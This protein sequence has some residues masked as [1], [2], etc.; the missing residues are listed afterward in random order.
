MASDYPRLPFPLPPPVSCSSCLGPS[1]TSYSCLFYDK[2]SYIW[3][4]WWLLFAGWCLLSEVWKSAYWTRQSQETHVLSSRALPASEFNHLVG[5]GWKHHPLQSFLLMWWN[6]KADI[7]A[8]ACDT[9]TQ[10]L[11][12][13]AGELLFENSITYIVSDL[14]VRSSQESQHRAIT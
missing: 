9:I 8:H 7:L 1:P 4:K 3:V 5:Q 2:L 12:V 10:W 11:K 13:E 14:Q 6:Q